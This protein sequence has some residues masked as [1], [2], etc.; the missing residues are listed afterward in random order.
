[1]T[2]A[3]SF[4][5]AQPNS[6]SGYRRDHR[7]FSSTSVRQ[8]WQNK[9]RSRAK[10]VGQGSGYSVGFLASESGNPERMV[11]LCFV[12]LAPEGGI[13]EGCCDALL[14][15]CC[16]KAAIPKDWCDVLLIF[17]DRRAATPKGRCELLLI[18]WPRRAATPSG[19]RCAFSACF[20]APKT[21]NR[22]GL[23][24]CSAD[25]LAPDGGNFEGVVGLCSFCGPRRAATPKE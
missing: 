6:F 4:L 16:R 8:R 18:L 3:S 19:W 2:Q 12:S 23:V 14:I 21:G 20:L 7:P 5:L 17:C 22:E 11:G 24:L 13:P 10:T 9:P 25:S 1:M 15:F